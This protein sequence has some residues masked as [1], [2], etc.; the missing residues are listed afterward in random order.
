MTRARDE[1]LPEVDKASDQ[2]YEPPSITTLGTLTEL[3]LGGIGAPED[4]F[5]NGLGSVPPP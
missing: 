1:S 5:G 3:T 4:G 2:A